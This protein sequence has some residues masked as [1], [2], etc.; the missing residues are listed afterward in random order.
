MSTS[1]S[2]LIAVLSLHPGGPRREQQAGWEEVLVSRG[3]ARP[4]L[5]CH[6]GQQMFPE[7]QLEEEQSGQQGWEGDA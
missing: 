6:L 3:V 2:I 4:L 5:M 1:L 7:S